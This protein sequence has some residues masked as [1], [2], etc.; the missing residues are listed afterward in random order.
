[1][2]LNQ[3]SVGL[4]EFKEK[5]LHSNKMGELKMCVGVVREGEV[6]QNEFNSASAADALMRPWK[7]HFVLLGLT[8]LILKMLANKT[9]AYPNN[10]VLVNN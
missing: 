2:C 1:M 8:Y 6:R 9:V 7:S 10:G 4:D 5:L 3:G